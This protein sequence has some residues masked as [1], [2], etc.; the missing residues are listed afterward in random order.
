MNAATKSAISA[1]VARIAAAYPH[2]TERAWVDSAIVS[3]HYNLQF[4]VDAVKFA[5]KIA[6]KLNIA[7]IAARPWG[8]AA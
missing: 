4:N 3:V 1:A 7:Q 5:H 8:Q 6:F 2:W